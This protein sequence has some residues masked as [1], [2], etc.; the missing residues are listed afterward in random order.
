MTR[1]SRSARHADR[2]PLVLAPRSAW[3]VGGQPRLSDFTP[4]GHV[5]PLAESGPKY[6]SRVH[7]AIK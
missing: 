4:A 5:V 3:A 1:A 2:E 7:S 6:G